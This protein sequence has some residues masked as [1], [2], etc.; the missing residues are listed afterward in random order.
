VVGQ[1]Q[2]AATTTITG[3][4]LVLGTV[5]TASSST[6]ASGSVIS[7]NPTAATQV[8]A[9]SAVNLL[10]STGPAQVAVPNVVGQTQAAATTT[11]TGAGLVL[12]TVTTAS[13]STVASGSVISTSPVAATQVIVGSAVNLVVST[14]P[15]QVAAPNITAQFTVTAGTAVLNR[16][17]GRYTQTVAVSNSGAALSAAA[18]VLDNLAAGYAVYQPT[19]V[20]VATTPA[21]S[22]FKEIGPAGAG[23]TVTFT[24]EF[25]RTGTPALTYTARILGAGAR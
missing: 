19:G 22:P 15:A 20:T 11:I 24:L 13:S 12:G 14:G 21:G 18:F 6:V 10:V 9:G 25:T 2:A 7:T 23:A 3:A 4:G 1:T 8:N 16:G 17:T 5:T